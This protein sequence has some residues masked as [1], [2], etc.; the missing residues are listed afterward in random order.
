MS[1]L[2]SVRLFLD[3][4]SSP[5]G[6]D[7]RYL[8]FSLTIPIEWWPTFKRVLVNRMM[9]RL[10]EHGAGA[11]VP[12]TAL[13]CYMTVGFLHE[14]LASF[15]AGNLRRDAPMEKLIASMKYLKRFCYINVH[16]HAAQVVVWEGHYQLIRLDGSQATVK[17]ML[18]RMEEAEDYLLQHMLGGCW[19][20]Q[21]CLLSAWAPLPVMVSEVGQVAKAYDYNVMCLRAYWVYRQ[22]RRAA[23]RGDKRRMNLVLNLLLFG[24]PFNPIN[25]PDGQKKPQTRLRVRTGR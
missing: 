15:M 5:V 6:N 21:P 4:Y 19:S 16:P 10:R 3:Q 7:G 22:L 8:G 24:S 14:T 25:K 2:E 18:K 11:D 23:L 13:C 9:L 20:E 1:L 12:G 17:S